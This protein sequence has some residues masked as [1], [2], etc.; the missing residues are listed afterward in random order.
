M[1]KK[2]KRGREEDCYAL[3]LPFVPFYKTSMKFRFD[4]SAEFH[5]VYREKRWTKDR[6]IMDYLVFQRMQDHINN[7]DKEHKTKNGI[8]TY[9]G[10]CFFSGEY[11]SA[12]AEFR[13]VYDKVTKR[14]DDTAE[15]VKKRTQRAIKDL[16]SMNLIEVVEKRKI[17]NNSLTITIYRMTMNARKHHNT[18][19][20][21]IFHARLMGNVK[22]TLTYLDID[23]KEILDED[24]NIVPEQLPFVISKRDE[25]MRN[26]IDSQREQIKKKDFLIAKLLSMVDQ[27]ALT[28]ILK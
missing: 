1:I 2:K 25:G 6:V 10:E 16:V 21:S 5:K 14:P 23:Y 28:D 20:N 11:F 12:N 7:T 13:D 9:T 27:N 18:E 19:N 8:I 22:K 24:G 26:T 3:Q 15:N 17:E 4:F